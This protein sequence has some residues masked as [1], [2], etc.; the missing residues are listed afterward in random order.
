M[1]PHPKECEMKIVFLTCLLG[2]HYLSL[3]RNY[4]LQ[5][6]DILPEIFYE[7]R[8]ICIYVYVCIFMYKLFLRNIQVLRYYIDTVLKTSFFLLN[9]IF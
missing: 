5:F 1:V 2:P 3:G 9:K 7:S 8:I 6:L 4:H